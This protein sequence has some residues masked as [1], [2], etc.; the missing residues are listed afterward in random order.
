MADLT[1]TQLRWLHDTVPDT[2]EDAA[3][4][5]RYD[6]LGSVRDVAL[7]ILRDKRKDL[8][9]SPLKVSLSGVASVDNAENVKALERS[10]AEIARLDDDPT[11]TPGEEAA[12]AVPRWETFNLTR[13][14]GR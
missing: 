9:D 12:A 11:S 7:S 8:L 3:L 13:S 1:P 5:A 6:E 4:Q 14:R 10:L 2:W